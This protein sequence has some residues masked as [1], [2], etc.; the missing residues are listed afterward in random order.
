M[1]QV[2]YP[3]AGNFLPLLNKCVQNLFSDQVRA[4]IKIGG[5]FEVRNYLGKP[6]VGKPV[7]GQFETLDFL[8][9]VDIV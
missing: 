3:Q 1:R 2:D 5:E 9:A 4:Q 8:V 6:F 7:L